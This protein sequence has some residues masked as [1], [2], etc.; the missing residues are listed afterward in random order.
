MT[1]QERAGKTR[2][3]LIEAAALEFAGRGY[4]GTSLHGISAIANTTIGALTFHFS[5]KSAL[6]DAVSEHGCD[7]TRETVLRTEL[8]GLPPLETVAGITRALA[9]L[10]EGTY[11][12]RA[13]ARLSRE[14]PGLHPEWYDSWMPAVRRLLAQA[15]REGS[16]RADQDAE[17]IAVLVGCLA[18]G[19]EATATPLC[20]PPVTRSWEAHSQVDEVWR[21]VCAGIGPPSAATDAS[22]EAG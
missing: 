20:A 6:A 16:L 10:L 1:K 21:V 18:A 13:A 11:V 17:T 14:R 5:V 9:Q 12:V 3:L 4:A 19:L 2:R 8:R 7:V 15:R 22:D